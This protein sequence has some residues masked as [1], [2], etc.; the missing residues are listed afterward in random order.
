MIDNPLSITGAN[1]R[2]IAAKGD[3]EKNACGISKMVTLLS[4]FLSE[5]QL[6]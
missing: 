1:H 2:I 6:Y 5:I 4:G 3:S